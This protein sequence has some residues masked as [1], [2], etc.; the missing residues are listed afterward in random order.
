MV[1]CLVAGGHLELQLLE[2]LLER[3]HLRRRH[4]R[5]GPRRSIAQLARGARHLACREAA[6]TAL[7]RAAATAQSGLHY[8]ILAAHR[9]T[10]RRPLLPLPLLPLLRGIA[11][12]L[13]VLL[14]PGK[15]MDMVSA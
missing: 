15:Y 10:A 2:R 8:A 11:V 5:R 14:V 3:R 4:G 12:G 13:E 9:A 7:P 6:V 1:A